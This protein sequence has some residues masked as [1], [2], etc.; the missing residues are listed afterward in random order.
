[1]ERTQADSGKTAPK[2]TKLHEDFVGKDDISH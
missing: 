2:Q 1:M